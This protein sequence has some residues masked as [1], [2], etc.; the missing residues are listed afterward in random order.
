MQI[1]LGS[2]FRVHGVVI[3][4]RADSYVIQWGWQ[5]V[6]EIL[7]S[8]SRT[9]SNFASATTTGSAV[10]T[11]FF[12][13]STSGNPIKS[14][15]YFNQPVV[16]RY[17][18]I[19][20]HKWI[21]S[22]STRAGV[23]TSLTT[24]AWNTCADCGAGAY[25][26][27]MGA[28]V[29]STCTACG[30][31]TYS[32]TTGASICINCGAGAYSPTTGAS[33]ASTCTACGAGK[34]SDAVIVTA[35][36]PETSRT[37]SSVQYEG[38]YSY[39]ARSMLDSALGWVPGNNYFGEWMQ[40]DLGSEFRVHGVV[41][42]AR[43][44]SYVIQWGWQYV[45]EILVSHSR[46]TSNFASATTTGSAVNTRFFPT[47]TSGNPIKSELYFNQPV[48]ARYIRIIV[49]KWI[50]SPSTRAGVLT[51]LTTA[52]WNTCAD[53]G[54][55]AYSPT[56]GA[57]VASTCTACGAGTYS[58]TTGASICINC[59]AG[60][61]S[62][63][64]GASVASTCTACGAGKYSDA[65]IVTANPPETSR[66]YSSVQYEGGYSYLARSMLDSALGWVPG[67]N[68][69]GEWMQIDLGSEFR[70]HGVV[71]QARA[72]SYVIQWGWQY[73]TEILVSH[74]RTTSN[75]ASATTTGS[76]VNTRF[77]PTSTSG[78]P[79]KS[80][81]YF[82][83]PVV[84]RY[85]RIIVHKWINSP[86]TRAGVLTSL[87]TAAWNTC[88]DCG[89]GTYSPTMG[90]SVASTCTACGAG[91]YSATTGASICINCGAGA[92]SPTT[93]ASVAST[94]TACGAGK[95]SDAVIVTANPP[96]TSRTYSSVQYEGGYSYLARSMLDS[97][98]GWVPG[99]NYF[100]EWMQIDLGS[101]FRVHGVVIQARADSYVIQWGWQYVTEILVSHSRTTSNFASATTTGS[102]VNTRFFPT[103]TSGNPI[104]SELYFNQPVVA[105]YIRIIVHKWINSPSTRAGVL[106]SLTTAA[107]N[108]CADCG[109]GAYSPTMG[110]SVASTCTACGAGT[111]SATTGA[112]ICINCGAGAY[113]P[114][115]GASVASTCTACGAG[116]YSDAVIV[117]ANP[118]ETS[119]TYSSVQ[120]EGGYSYL[121][122]SML[123]SALGWV[124]GNNYFGEWMQI[125][126]GSEFRVH[127]VVIQARAD[128][129]VIQWGWQYVTEILVSHSRTTSNFASA[130]TTG[131][132]VNTR[133]FPTS[134]SGNPIKSE[135][136]F[137][138]PVVARYI[139]IIVHKWINS[140]STRAG[141]LTSLTTAAWN[142]CADC[143]AGA[144][145]PTMGASVAST[146]T[147]CGAGTYSATTGA[148]I[149]INCGAGAYSPTTGASVAS[150]CTAC[151]AG[152]YSDAVIVTANPPETS[153][154]YSSVQYEGGY[155]YLARSMLD[156]ALGWVP[157]NNYF[158]EWMQ[159]DLGSE[160][161]VH[162]VVIQARADSYVIQWGWQYV[163]EILVSHSRTTS[164]FASAT[165]TGSAVNTRFFPTSTSGN[166]IKSEL[167]F[168][169]PVVARYIRI[170][171]HKWINSPS[172]RAGVLTSLTT[173]AWNTCAD[174]GAGAYSPT[175]GAS[176]A[177]T[178]TACGAG[179]YSA[180]TG[181]SIC[182][183]CGAGAYS[184]TTG[185][186]VA[187]TCTAC[188][189]GKYSDAVIVTANPPETSRTYSSVQYEGGYSYLAR[190]MLDSALGWVPGNNYFGEWMQIDLGSE[191][192]VHGVVIQARADSYVIQ[193]GWQYVT[194]ILV[195]H[196]R[197][198]SNFA[199]ATTTGSAVNTRFFP[200]STSGNPIK[201]ELYFNQ[202]VV[203][204]YIRIIVHKWINSPS[205]RAGVL[206]SLTTAAWN[207]CADCGAGAYSPTMGA[208]VA[209]TC[210][211][212][213]AGTYSA[214]T[215]AS[216][217]INCGAGAYSPTTGA[218]VASTCTACGAGKFLSNAGASTCLSCA[219]GSVSANTMSTTC[220]TCPAGSYSTSASGECQL[221]PAGFF[222]LASGA[223]SSAACA[224]C[225]AG[226]T[227]HSSRTS[228]TPCEAGK[229]GATTRA[230]ACMDCSAGKYADTPGRS[231]CTPCE[232]AAGSYCPSG[233]SSA[234]GVPCPAGFYCPGASNDKLPCPAGKSAAGVNA[235]ACDN[236]EAGKHKAAAGINTA[237]GNKTLK[238]R[239]AT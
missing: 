194:E 40:I 133:F 136:Y 13:T 31:G 43:A 3:Q 29:A 188:G 24:A 223:T 181:A 54:A 225:D 156:S 195:S 103:S 216:I 46:T 90:A 150:T 187:S 202:P 102:A 39:L 219:A 238:N 173:A 184:P 239:V 41:I 221:C 160:F 237:C 141:V 20:V 204:R 17:I 5:Y 193:W 130:T 233:S 73:V 63:T 113:S 92:Y 212:C 15:L 111:Y 35:N 125:D 76:A 116:K 124:P 205:T 81:L 106:T 88:A 117:T 220:V 164:N 118:P 206:T 82:N 165:T 74:S 234:A 137:N 162:G 38:G 145:S 101:E 57:S 231:A 218:S 95:Y 139:R 100:G 178:C 61:Y 60:A 107:W 213:G 25:S 86:S 143:G 222:S 176:V 11:R 149:C 229:Y 135:L 120:Y 32:A 199:S 158:G 209:S 236:C 183:N 69:F 127:G 26:P 64:T 151:G 45:T 93:G 142:T 230:S 2:E 55:G 66:T 166:P 85:I 8:H 7:V 42:Q 96:E 203:A 180:T 30:A 119:R 9:T 34:Y 163:T 105:R 148:S 214:T 18:R 72:D 186:S 122:R 146:C 121:A 185:A 68:Y 56:M 109:A 197:T 169:Q 159:I 217:C 51:S 157:G 75:F 77:F 131:S 196:S 179:T 134:T 177:S 59:G 232:A 19:I 99:N 155:S 58:A 108:T 224:S 78:N 210:T 50:N 144:Y 208:S 71:I 147:A 172:T 4:A 10:N 153:R 83:Q 192:R 182:I 6:T 161:R 129:Y 89:A 198:T 37:Y 138:Q 16:A 22:P 152:K 94:C 1:D 174:C 97:A 227:S 126:L 12:P 154:T 52:A 47:S 79:I 53:C 170:I 27:T 67:N 84:A 36:P 207:T 167:Y 215:G 201:S 191:F 14:E 140:P 168:N 91:T 123:D 228:C 189:A 48:V 49:H 21:N 128:S 80:E 70:V 44:D 190:S 112:S 28:S 98:L 200:T 211:A 62:P 33:V 226:T 23:L 175:M 171:V 235:A 104:K 110:A 114:T 132:A 65:V 87:T 115:T